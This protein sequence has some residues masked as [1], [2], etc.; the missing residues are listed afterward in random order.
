MSTQITETK[1]MFYCP[2]AKKEIPK[3]YCPGAC[4]VCGPKNR[5]GEETYH[6]SG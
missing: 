1:K 3:E 4:Y 2:T 6:W 5:N